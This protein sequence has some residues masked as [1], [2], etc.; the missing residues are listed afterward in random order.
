MTENEFLCAAVFDKMSLK[1]T[2]DKHTLG[3][4]KNPLCEGVNPYP[5]DLNYCPF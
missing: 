5:A 2:Y 4:P 1:E 3:V